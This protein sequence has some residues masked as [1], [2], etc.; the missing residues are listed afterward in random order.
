MAAINCATI[1]S[2]FGMRAQYST[3]RVH[4]PKVQTEKL[5]SHYSGN[6]NRMM[7]ESL[8][9]KREMIAEAISALATYN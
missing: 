2:L 7:N 5:A 4:Y 6:A 8:R 3:V 1:K 9:T